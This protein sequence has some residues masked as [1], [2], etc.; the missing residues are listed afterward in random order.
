MIELGRHSSVN[1]GVASPITSLRAG[2]V[3]TISAV[4]FTSGGALP[5][6]PLVDLPSSSNQP[7]QAAGSTTESRY[8][9]YVA[10]NMSMIFEV[11]A[12]SVTLNPNLITE[13]ETTTAT[14]IRTGSLLDPLTV[15]LSNN[16]STE[17]THLGTV[18]IPAGISSADFTVTALNDMEL[19][20]AQ[21][22]VIT[23]QAGGFTSGSATLGVNDLL[24]PSLDFGDSPDRPTLLAD[25][26][27]RHAVGGPR[28]GTTID[29]EADG[30][31]R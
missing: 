14:V 5:A 10:N 4:P 27:A 13:E 6:I 2:R 24:P 20:A 22:V 9:R 21:S 28:L 8:G 30:Q 12:L 7:I 1:A 17:V 16:D 26:S 18:T 15:N 11:E 31:T 25:D 23:A 19:D 29:T 3:H